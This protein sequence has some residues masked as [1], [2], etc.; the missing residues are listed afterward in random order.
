MELLK[1]R[2]L[3]HE[4]LIVLLVAGV[5]SSLMAT[6]MLQSA[7]A[8]GSGDWQPPLQPANWI[9]SNSTSIENETYVL[10]G[11]MIVNSSWLYMEN[12]TI[13]F[14]SSIT[15][16]WSLWSNDSHVYF[17]NC[18][19]T[20]L[21][22]ATWFSATVIGGTNVEIINTTVNHCT[23]WIIE[24]VSN[25]VISKSDFSSGI[26]GITLKNCSDF[27]ISNNTI[28]DNQGDGI[29]VSGSPPS[30]YSYSPYEFINNSVHHNGGNGFS[31]TEMR[32]GYVHYNNISFNGKA[33]LFFNQTQAY[34]VNNTI[35]S[36]HDDGIEAL[37]YN[38]TMW[39]DTYSISI[40]NNTI[41]SNTGNGVHFIKMDSWIWNNNIS[42]NGL[43]GIRLETSYDGLDIYYN[44]VYDNEGNGL[45]SINSPLCCISEIKNNTME[46]N[47]GHGFF[48]DHVDHVDIE[49]NVATNN[50][51]SGFVFN[52]CSENEIHFNTVINNS[53]YGMFFSK[54]S[55]DNTL[56]NN[57]ITSN[58][59]G[60]IIFDGLVTFENAMLAGIC[61][62]AI[63]L[64]LA[65]V[66]FVKSR[67]RLRETIAGEEITD[68]KVT[69]MARR[70]YQLAMTLKTWL[71]SAA[72]A[73]GIMVAFHFLYMKIYLDSFVIVALIFAGI[74]SLIMRFVFKKKGT[75][76]KGTEAI[77]QVVDFHE[78]FKHI[79]LAAYLSLDLAKDA[80]KNK[81]PGNYL[82]YGLV[83]HRLFSALNDK[84]MM[85][86]SELYIIDGCI[87]IEAFDEAMEHLDAARAIE[88]SFQ[89]RDPKLKLDLLQAKLSAK[90]DRRASFGKEYEV[91]FGER[92]HGEKM[93]KYKDGQVLE[94]QVSSPEENSIDIVEARALKAL[95]TIAGKVSYEIKE[96]HI[97]NL[98]LPAKELDCI[99]DVIGTFQSLEW[100]T[101]RSNKITCLP[102]S[103]GDLTTLK[104]LDLSHNYIT[105]L[106]ATLSR[107]TALERIDMSNN[108]FWHFPPVLGKIPSLTEILANN[109][110]LGDIDGNI[111][112]IVNLKKL[113]LSNNHIKEIP[114]SAGKLAKLEWLDIAT[115]R[116]TFIPTTFKELKELKYLN[117]SH[118]MLSKM[119]SD[120]TLIL[121][122][123][124]RRNEC[125]IK[126]ETKGSA[127]T[128]LFPI[129]A[130]FIFT[131]V[132]LTTSLG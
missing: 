75:I 25:P 54:Y 48:F 86:A 29:A 130:Y 65:M 24:N 57:T 58:L 53:E 7:V 116:I 107:C 21:D 119:A 100:L 59:R 46:R 96:G 106:P 73:I 97:H 131:I 31:V 105:R 129:I 101:L 77:E 72:V 56:R 124:K 66:S 55:R 87:E 122:I 27:T 121:E 95:E 61:V 26:T 60:D 70:D 11:N 94:D 5:F 78:R 41:R 114:D 20:V 127:W 14:N 80:M 115:N 45:T 43:D 74:F 93:T 32:Y 8:T 10:D 28:H 88:L 126:N 69:Y 13:I 82:G 132:N 62:A 50:T 19:F 47:H 49:N 84:E 36:N 4:K 2:L 102:E 110:K 15:R 51:G 125:E 85:L 76:A 3:G 123:L 99:P 79:K 40:F 112:D 44:H 22:P 90:K 83:A 98:S 33:G 35:L 117:I 9:I 120:T 23:S 6:N 108:S 63:G 92:G 34:L 52:V 71:I 37:V 68:P 17:V 42:M 1:Y 111:G 16:N 109:N 39:W 30:G 81:I 104:R 67:P 18:T 91:L 118:N 12:V 64:L 113:D 128:V 103:I 38:D 89:A